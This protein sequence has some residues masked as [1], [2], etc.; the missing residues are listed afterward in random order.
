[1]THESLEGYELELYELG[2]V[3]NPTPNAFIHFS[4][5]MPQLAQALIAVEKAE[6]D[7]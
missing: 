7:S 4:S 2:D 1:M 5:G 6:Q 3:V